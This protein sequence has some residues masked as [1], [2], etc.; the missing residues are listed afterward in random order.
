[1][2][3]TRLW[4]VITVVNVLGNKKTAEKIE[5]FKSY[6]RDKLL[7]LNARPFVVSRA[8]GEAEYGRGRE[9]RAR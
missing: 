8:G 4:A 3:R 5:E 1:M 9:D 6:H 2:E 7:R